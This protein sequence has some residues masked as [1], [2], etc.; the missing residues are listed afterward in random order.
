MK[1]ESLESRMRSRE[2]F[3][4]LRVLPGAW[5]VLRM[6]GRGFSH[7]TEGRYEKPFD[8]SL[9]ALMVQTTRALV[10]DFQALY[11]YTESDELS[12]LLRPDAVPFDR[13]VE[14][15]VSLSAARAAATFSVGASTPATFD[16]RVWLGASVEDV[17]DYFRWRQEDAARCALHGWCYW[18]LRKEGMDVREAT[19]TLHGASVE[20]KHELLHARGIH[21]PQL[22]AWQRR[23]T[24]VL[25]SWHEKQGVDPRSGRT[26]TARRRHLHT[27]EEL[28]MKDAY[29]DFLRRLMAST[30]LDT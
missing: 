27:E 4:T 12:I 5:V 29:A 6:D 19:M 30:P 14:K 25:W 18:T 16:S 8:A 10:E 22:P 15:L 20:A 3:H 28:P 17:V 7:F 24:G 2:V 9:H 26:V 21:F 1:R 13:E 23:G 11:G